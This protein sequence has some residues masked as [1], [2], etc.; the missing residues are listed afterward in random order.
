MPKGPKL[1]HVVF[2]TH[3][4]EE[5]KQFYC[6]LLGAHV[7]YE[8]HDLCFLTHDEEHHRIA[9]LR[10]PELQPRPD[11]VAAMHHSAFTFDQ[12]DDL[13][14]AYAELKAK[15]IEPTMPIQ[16]GVTTSLYY[17]DP[18]GNFVELQVDNFATPEEATTYM[19]GPEY[20]ADP[21]GPRYDPEALL[22]AV[23]AGVPAADLTNRAWALAHPYVGDNE[24]VEV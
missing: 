14:D 11:N 23:R 17:Q 20:D 6:D 4:F 19:R 24:W 16:H 7:V 13:V 1:V 18:D 2:Q 8:G 3:Q 22:A 21:I 10:V 5:M 15:G 12:L 9:L